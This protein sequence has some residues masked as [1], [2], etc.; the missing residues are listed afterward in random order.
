MA[1]PNPREAPEEFSNFL[2]TLNLDIALTAFVHNQNRPTAGPDGRLSEGTAQD[3]CERM[4]AILVS[5][6]S[7]IRVIVYL[8]ILG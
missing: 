2:K 5:F 3:W 8:S 4:D 6:F 7:L 1:H